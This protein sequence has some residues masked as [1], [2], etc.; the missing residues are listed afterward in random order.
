MNFL[1]LGLIALTGV[2]MLA[3]TSCKKYDDNTGITVRTVKKRLVGSWETKYDITS[4]TLSTSLGAVLGDDFSNLFGGDTT[5]DPLS[6]EITQVYTFD[7]DEDLTV[8]TTLPPQTV[9]FF[10]TEFTI[11]GTTTSETGKWEFS[12]DKESIKMTLDGEVTEADI[13]LLTMKA[14]NLDFP[15]LGDLSLFEFTKLKE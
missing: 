14:L 3:T 13:K 7:K 6:I 9:D 5:G 8:A 11:P 4:E 10:G 1:K 2:A 12:D 15:E